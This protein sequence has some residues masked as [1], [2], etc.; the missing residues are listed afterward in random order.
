MSREYFQRR[1]E[2]EKRLAERASDS[3]IARI[4]RE[5]RERYVQL[6]ASENRVPLNMARE[7]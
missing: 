7:R 1:A 2:Q 5:L 3:M 4:H 6:A